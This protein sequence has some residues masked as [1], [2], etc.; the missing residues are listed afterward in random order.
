VERTS[1]AGRGA[2][3]AGERRW[4]PLRFAKSR[5]AHSS[6]SSSF[7]AHTGDRRLARP[8]VGGS[9]YRAARPGARDDCGAV[10]V[11]GAF[12]G[13]RASYVLC[14]G[15]RRG[16]GCTASTPPGGVNPPSM[17]LDDTRW[18]VDAVRSGPVRS[19]PSEGRLCLPTFPVPG[20]RRNPPW[21]RRWCSLDGPGGRRPVPGHCK[22][23][24]QGRGSA[25]SNACGG[26]P[27]PAS[28]SVGPGSPTAPNEAM[29]D[30]QHH[31]SP[32]RS[33]SSRR[34]TGS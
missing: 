16:R 3:G 7:F 13:V 15:R 9:C 21:R 26:R 30:R 23:Y 24:P 14:L 10:C 34:R 33:R 20:R 28:S 1:R 22:Q 12:G 4:V 19:G 18:L 31:H 8:P 6:S 32:S 27:R 17:S 11:W 25:V 5:A 2:A 29:E